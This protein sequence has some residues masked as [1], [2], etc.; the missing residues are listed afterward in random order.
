MPDGT[1]TGVVF[2]LDGVVADTEHLWEAAWTACCKR[3]GR[4]WTREDTSGVQGM[5]APEWARHIAGLLGTPDAV[6]EVEDFCVTY[7]VDAVAAGRGPLL[8]GAY[9]LVVD[10]SER[11]PV[12]LASSAARRVIDAVL[13][14]HDLTSSFTA[15]VSSAEVLRGKP[16]PDVYLEA[17][18]RIGCGAGGSRDASTDDMGTCLAVEDSGNGIRAAHAAGLHVVAIPNPVYPPAPEA[19][20]LADFVAPDHAAARAYVLER[21]GPERLRPTHG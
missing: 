15:T 18:R 16:S 3:R 9:D 4:A 1:V 11:V 7:V 12:A 10:V 17:A 14:H 21:I 6:R 13:T 8:E 19:L 5:S 20:A 2:D